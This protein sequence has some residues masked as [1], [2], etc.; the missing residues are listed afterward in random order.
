MID[1]F[2]HRTHNQKLPNRVNMVTH[3]GTQEQGLYL[4]NEERK[5]IA[6]EVMKNYILDE[7]LLVRGLRKHLNNILLSSSCLFH[8]ELPMDKTFPLVSKPNGPSEPC[9]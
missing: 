1:L 6:L 8:S 5:I 2:P 9:L 3:T 7:R 4:S